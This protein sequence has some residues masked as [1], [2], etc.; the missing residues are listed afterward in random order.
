MNPSAKGRR[1]AFVGFAIV[2]VVCVAPVLSAQVVINELLAENFDNLA[3][4][5]GDFTDW[6]ELYLDGD[7]PVSLDGYSLTDDPD[8]TSNWAL[9]AVE[10][11]PGERLL[12]F[13]SGKDRF[14][15]PPGSFGGNAVSGFQPN[16]IKEGDTWRYLVGVP[17][18]PGP[19]DGWYERDFD[20][21]GWDSGESG[22][23]YDDGDD[24]TIV[25]D[26]TPVVFTRRRFVVE[27]PRTITNLILRVDFDD[28]F[29]AYLNGIRVGEHGAPAGDPTF[30]SRATGKHE[31]GTPEFIDLGAHLGSLVA[32]ENVLAVAGLNDTPS[33]D[34]S[35]IVELGQVPTYV[36][37]SFE[38]NKDG[39]TVALI[40][41]GG[42]VVDS[43]DFPVQ[44]RDHSYGR[45]GDGGAEWGYFV[46]PTPDAPNG[47]I[48][49]IDPIPDEVLITPG[50]GVY[51]GDVDVVLAANLPGELDIRYTTNGEAPTASSRLYTSAISID[52]EQLISAAGFRGS[53]RVTPVAYANYFFGHDFELP[54]M[55]I[56]M[57]PDDYN[58][59]HTSGGARGRSSERRAHMEYLIDDEVAF[60][61]DFGMRLHGG[62]SRGGDINTKKSYKAYFRGIY[63]DKKLDYPIIPATA[64]DKFDKLVLRAGFNDGFRGNGRAAYVRDQVIRD[65][66]EDMGMIVSH[67]SWCNLFVNMRFRGL[68]NIVERMDEEFLEPYTGDSEWDVIKTGND[69]LVGTIDEWRRVRNFVVDG[70]MSDSALFVQALRMIDIENFTSYMLLNIWAQN[71]DWPHNNWYAARPRRPDGKWI[72]LSWDA[73]F[74]IGLIPSG[75]SEDTFEFVFTRSG[76]LRDILNGLLA[77]A[78]YRRYFVNEADRHRYEALS[79]E[80]V[81]GHIDH[82]A[83][84][85]RDDINEEAELFSRS[86]SSWESNIRGCEEFARRRGPIFFNDIQNSGRFN[87]PGVTVPRVTS[88]SPESVLVTGTE[89][90]TLIG[91]RLEAATRVF[92]NGTLASEQS[93]GLGRL[94]VT[95]PFDLSLD[96]PVTVTVQHPATQES[97]DAPMLLDVSFPR[98]VATQVVP[99]AGSSGGGEVVQ[100]SGQLFWPGI[101]VHFG[102]V[103]AERVEI[104]SVDPYLLEVV[105]PP[106]QGT[107]DVTLRN[108]LPG[109]AVPAEHSLT[110]RYVDGGFMRGD[111]N[112][113]ADVDISD[114]IGILN[115][116]FTADGEILCDDAADANDSGLVDVSDAIYLFGFLFGGIEELPAPQGF[117]ANDPTADGLGCGFAGSC[118]A[119]N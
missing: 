80:R 66:H 91:T 10:L 49:E 32:G 41:P 79:P 96:G 109:G 12:V 93:F 58:T 31:A 51:A 107:V 62:A 61:T 105:T 63:G 77:N 46:T 106:G 23:G 86:T 54:I 108:K 42:E 14:V 89:T 25:P 21:G 24:E 45:V 116:L 118:A 53:T 81:L 98:P 57:D 95:V 84:A 115:G 19:P 29:I 30:D 70:D 64:I 112:G 65:I 20:D 101:E 1:G 6:L 85:I 38:L 33:S 73:E 87:F 8:L 110:Y 35:L 36:H 68:F 60:G 100:I 88:V 71:H 5:D 26:D 16:Y 7:V 43:V 104:L 47:T 83:D 69:V 50:T 72:F 4:E 18:E 17:G 78:D 39:E 67:G 82:H 114:P 37:A 94:T 15:P 90:V 55:A 34:M 74:G 76:Y 9:P 113:D 22:F 13:M 27:D 2:V 103:P 44:T 56:T 75:Y 117:C 99:A 92:F 119:A 28:G 52:D 102:D 11:Q 97:S 48:F 40:S 111:A 59:V 3:D